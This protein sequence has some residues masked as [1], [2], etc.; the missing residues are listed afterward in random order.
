M[1]EQHDIA[2]GLKKEVLEMKAEKSYWWDY[3]TKVKRDTKDW[4]K[5]KKLRERE[6]E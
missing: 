2:E 6:N 5:Y 1:N 4:L 3:L